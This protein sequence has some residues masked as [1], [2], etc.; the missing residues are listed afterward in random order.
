MPEGLLN[1]FTRD[2]IADLLAF[3]EAGPAAASSKARGLPY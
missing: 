3:L 2:E 1:S